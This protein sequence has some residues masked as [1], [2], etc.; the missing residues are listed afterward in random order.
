MTPADCD[1]RGMPF[2]P[3][4]TVRLLDSDL[5]ILSSGDQFKAAVALWC[6]SWNQ[7]PG[8]SLPDNDQI[9][10]A[11]SGSKVWKKVREM[12]LRGWVKCSDGRLYHPVVAQ[13]AIQ[14]WESRVDHRETNESRNERQARW[15]KKVKEM[16]E[17][18]RSV[19][20]TPPMNASLA[21]L[22]RLVLLHVDNHVDGQTSTEASTQ[23]SLVDDSET[24]NKRRDSKGTGK[25]KKRGAKAPTSAGLPTWLQALIDLWHEVL[26]ELPGV[27]VMNAEREQAA[28]DFRHWVLTTP[29]RDGTPRANDDV[30]FLAWTRDYFER[31]RHNDFIMGRGA[32]SPGHENWRCPFEWLL[33]AKGMQKVIEQ[34]TEAA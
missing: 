8:G 3:L 19:N 23:A 2:M 1:L 31:A 4:E 11:L 26:P 18:L 14:A 22:E 13:N 10:E 5:F 6:K 16:S 7:I 21:E 25:G 32:R 28:K 9:L 12:A 34:T 24:A 27:V 29:R 33:S 17:L 20:V 15:R 30:E